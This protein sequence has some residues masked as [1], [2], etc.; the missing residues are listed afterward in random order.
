VLPAVVFKGR[1]RAF[2][3]S[4]IPHTKCEQICSGRRLVI[5]ATMQ[6]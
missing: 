4:P 3:V 5:E 1:G 2:R 6:L